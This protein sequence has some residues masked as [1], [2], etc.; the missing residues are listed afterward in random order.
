MFQ[1]DLTRE[2]LTNFELKEEQNKVKAARKEQIKYSC[3]SDVFHAFIFI[4]IYFGHLLSGYAIMAAVGL[5]T[6]CAIVLA[7][8][9]R[10][11]LNRSDIFSASIIAVGAGVAVAFILQLTMQQPLL[12]SVLAGILVGSIVIIGATL[13]RKIKWV[14]TLTEDLKPVA[15]DPYAQQEIADLCR[16]HPFLA[17]YRD[18]AARYL[19]PHLTYGELKAM[20]Q[21]AERDQQDKAVG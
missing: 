21:W 19:R 7:T 8:T 3:I 12:G 16:K 18:Q 11:K 20:R 15:E 13:G 17:E 10:N 5:G 1:F 2:A 4:A 14:M 6:T 9:T